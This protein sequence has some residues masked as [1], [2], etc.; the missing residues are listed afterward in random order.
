MRK[1]G[2]SGSRGLLFTGIPLIAAVSIG[3]SIWGITIGLGNKNILNSFQPPYATSVGSCPA[4]E[5]RR[6][7]A[8]TV[9]LNVNTDE[10]LRAVPCHVNNGDENQYADRR[11]QYTKTMLHDA[12]TG[13]VAPGYYETLLSGVAQKNFDGMLRAPL[14]TVKYTNPLGGL[15]VNLV[16]S[17]S[18]ALTIPPPPKFNSLEQAVEYVENAW[19]A[20]LR[21]VPFDQYSTNPNA[22]LAAAELMTNATSLFRGN[23]V[24]HAIG[25]YISQFFYL[26]CYYGVNPIDMRVAPPAA[27]R[28]YLTNM[29][30]WLNVQNGKAPL[31]SEAFESVPRYMINARDIGHFVHYDMLF[32]AYHQAAMVL[33]RINAPYNPTNPYVSS[34]NQMGFATFG[35]PHVST[36]VTE[37]S[38]RALRTAW[39]QKWFV[40]RRM[41]PEIF[42]ARVDRHKK[43]LATFDMHPF[44]LNST[45]GTMLNATYGGYFIPQAYPE[46]SPTH[47]SY[48]AGHATVA[49]A[50]VTILKAIF[51]G[52]FVIPAPLVPNANGSAL[53]NYTG[54]TL[55]VEGELNKI[56]SNVGMGR[57]LAGVHWR[58]DYEA[59][60]RLG[61]QVA[62]ATLRDHKAAFPE[63]FQGW[64][65][66]SFDG[67][68]ITI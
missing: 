50:C 53:L 5:A 28:D 17:D 58:S 38:D 67:V 48:A 22:I 9:R 60:V 43:G 31:E 37:V 57:N 39:Y 16:G 11:A 6:N 49:G 46:G 2:G 62:I 10:F 40:A 23:T 59:S 30:T 65:F 56:A 54:D 36:L 34:A 44:A 14:A 51:D 21:D 41:R 8:Y 20:I 42:G 64:R 1:P 19:M 18:Q 35:G 26:P 27:N 25:P 33:F 32:Q 68:V 12:T 4:G 55:T 7:Q 15:A 52:S 47:P 29:T 66:T 13:L 61:E 45:A 3:L 24:G 63:P